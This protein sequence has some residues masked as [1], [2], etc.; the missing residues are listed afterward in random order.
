MMEV[1]GYR[2]L[3]FVHT[4]TEADAKS[5]GPIR[6]ELEFFHTKEA[7]D[8]ALNAKYRNF[9]CNVP[10]IVPMFYCVEEIPRDKRPT[11]YFNV[12]EPDVEE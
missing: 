8:A 7:A 9:T 12:E 6:Q 1:A 4:G 2:I 10:T 5:H 11:Y 3:R